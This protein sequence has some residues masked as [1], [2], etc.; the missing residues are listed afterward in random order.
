MR[1]LFSGLFGLI[2]VVSGFSQETIDTKTPFEK[3]VVIKKADGTLEKRRVIKVKKIGENIELEKSDGAMVL[4]PVSS[5]IA[6][7]PQYPTKGQKYG[8]EDVQ[9][10]L[11]ILRALPPEHAPSP[12]EIKQW[13]AM[14]EILIASTPETE[15]STAKSEVSRAT[16]ETTKEGSGDTTTVGVTLKSVIEAEELYQAC[17]G[18]LGKEFIGKSVIVEGTIDQAD[19][20]SLIDGFTKPKNIYLVGAPKP[21]GGHYLVKCEVRGPVIFLFERGNLYAR[22]VRFEES[23]SRAIYHTIDGQTIANASDR[24]DTNVEFPLIQQGN[25][26]LIA[27]KMKIVGINRVGDLELVGANIQ[28][29]ALSWKQIQEIS[30]KNRTKVPKTEGSSGSYDFEALFIEI[31]R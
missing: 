24:V 10:A 17:K 6:T 23:L 26:V 3:V 11:K 27:Q 25:R 31:E 16:K 2:L 22:Y 13:E 9:N 15:A 12:E 5:I 7:I 14:Q 8:L 18:P 19:T 20:F 1:F 29:E 21:G 30:G 28:K 4:L